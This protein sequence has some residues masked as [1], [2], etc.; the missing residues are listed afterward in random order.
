[1]K[2]YDKLVSNAAGRIVPTEING[3]DQ[4]PYMGIG[5]HKPSG[6]KY[7]PQIVSCSD[8]PADGNKT[9]PSLKD[10]LIKSGLRDGMVISTHH[11]FRNG[12]LI[13]I[14][15][16]DIAKEMG[17]KDLVWF[18]SAS[19]ECQSVLVKYLEDGTIHHIEGSMNGS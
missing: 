13:A 2:K 6:R 4:Y 15:I 10:A 17:I 14:Q 5:K 8:Y 11:H 9:I 19:F 12:D 16:F 18:P 7:A 1:M 3:V